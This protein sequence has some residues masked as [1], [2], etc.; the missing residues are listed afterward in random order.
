MRF[1]HLCDQNWVGMAN[2][3]VEADADRMV[4]VCLIEQAVG[5]ESLARDLTECLQDVSIRDS[6]ALKLRFDHSH[7]AG[8]EFSFV[9]GHYSNII[10]NSACEAHV[11]GH[12]HG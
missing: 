3:F 9:L 8:G 7:A 11:R 6:A 10:S 12:E 5:Q 1:L 2:A 4:L